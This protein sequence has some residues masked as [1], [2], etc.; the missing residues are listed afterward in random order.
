MGLRATRALIGRL[1]RR[2]FLGNSGVVAAASMV[3]CRSAFRSSSAVEFRPSSRGIDTHTHFYDPTRPAGVPWPAPDDSVLYR[4]VLPQDYR[5][6]NGAKEMEGTVVVEASPWVEDNQWILDLASRHTFI[7]GFVGN[8]P[9]GAP[10]FAG[11]LERFAGNPI[12]RGI[13]VQGQQLRAGL[14]EVGF[15]RDLRRVLEAGLSLDVVG[16]PDLLPVVSWLAAKLP[17]LSIIVDH[18]AGVRIDGAEPPSEWRRDM[19]LAARQPGVFCKVSGL[20]EGTGRRGGQAPTD[21][22]FYRPL[23]DFVAGTFGPDRLIYGS[24][25]PVCEHFAT[26]ETVHRLVAEYF[27]ASEAT[28]TDRVFRENARRAY[29][30]VVRSQ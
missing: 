30:W 25:W 1:S 22:A 29:R 11:L 13:R 16:G 18:L 4:R 12:F 20:V 24:N 17:G 27:E 26:L 10:G 23:L 2:R 8:L 5:A 6:L 9:V 21:P 15:M 14:S 3:G 19:E 7:V 28:M